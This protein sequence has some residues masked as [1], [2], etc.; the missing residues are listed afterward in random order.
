MMISAKK[1]GPATV[2]RLLI[3]DSEKKIANLQPGDSELFQQFSKSPMISEKLCGLALLAKRIEE[4]RQ[5]SEILT[6]IQGGESRVI[7]NGDHSTN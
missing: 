2:Y 3:D 5:V 6:K 7:Q 4:S 1:E